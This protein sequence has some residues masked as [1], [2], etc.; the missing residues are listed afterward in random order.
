MTPPRDERGLTREDI[1]L[2]METYDNMVKP[3]TELL[4]VS[5]NILDNVDTIVK[6]LDKCSEKLADIGSDLGTSLTEGKG[7]CKLDHE[8]I[9]NKV[10]IAWPNKILVDSE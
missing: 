7:Q 2:L 10:H 3:L 8:K 9:G 4:Q 6:R 5:S 1:L